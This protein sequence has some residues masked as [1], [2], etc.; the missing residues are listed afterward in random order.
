M[1][2]TP[3]GSSTGPAM[4]RSE[5]EAEIRESVARGDYRRAATRVLEVFGPEVL[6]F[7]RARLRGGSQA[8]DAYLEFSEDLWVGLPAFRWESSLR[9]WLFV[10]A[11]NAATRIG[12]S[13][14]REVPLPSEHG[15]YPELQEQVRSSTAQ[16]LRTAVKDRM[17]EIR[18]RLAEDDQTLLIL[19][20]DRRL[21]WRELAVVMNEVVDGASEEEL[22]R[23]S[24]RVRTRFQAAKKRLRTLAEAE[25]LLGPLPTPVLRRE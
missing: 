4:T 7:L 1:V 16:Y 23:A 11:R 17:R 18:Q 10:L 6:R 24:A 12:R 21:E 19:R 14:R 5:V 20:V 13:R 9:V 15:G 2:T 8:E 25:G 3:P 22:T